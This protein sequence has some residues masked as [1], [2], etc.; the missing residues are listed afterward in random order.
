MQRYLWDGDVAERQWQ[1]ATK[2][3]DSALEIPGFIFTASAF[4][5]AQ[6]D[7]TA[8]LC[9]KEAAATVWPSYLSKRPNT[10][11]GIKRGKYF[12]L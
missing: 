8:A 11:H 10:Q 1:L 2:L 5:L 3:P 9:V 12:F 6:L 7:E 4:N